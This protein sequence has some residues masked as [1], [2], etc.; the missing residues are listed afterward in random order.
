[1]FYKNGDKF[2]VTSSEADR[3]SKNKQLCASVSFGVINA[4]ILQ[5]LSMWPDAYK[6]E[7]ALTEGQVKWSESKMLASKGSK[8]VRIRVGGIL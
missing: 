3:S 5:A 6:S 4:S 7:G 8:M 1:L 2:Y